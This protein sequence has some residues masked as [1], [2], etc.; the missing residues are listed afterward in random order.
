LIVA[1]AQLASSQ[2]KP[3]NL[4][5]IDRLARQAAAKGAQ[6]IVFPEE[7]M[8]AGALG[9]PLA[10]AAETLEGPFATTVRELASE[11][12]VTLAAGLYE[13]APDDPGRV[14]N[15]IA[16]A[17]ASGELQTYRKLH[18]FDA[19]GNRESDRVVEG[20]GARL[21]LV[22]DGIRVGF[23]NCYD[24]RFPELARLLIDDGAELLVVCASWAG[25][26]RKDDQWETLLRARAIENTCWVAAADQSLDST[27]G[28]S[29]L[30]DPMGVVRA[31]L[32]DERDAL[33][34]GE[35]DAARTAEVRALVPSIQN[36]RFRVC[37]DV[38]S[39]GHAGMS[40]EA[41]T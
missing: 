18:L 37:A 8:Y 3:R 15:T 9:E 14:H 17:H 29:M 41:L 25:G 13:H 28:R 30:V 5:V 35:V 27:V 22:V 6:L 26:N 20:A 21:T 34:V 12:G 2:D 31:S 32:G 24:I 19:F 38:T 36:R 33:V 7:S 40:E 4:R 39:N 23:L 1:L 10:E 11:L 16:V